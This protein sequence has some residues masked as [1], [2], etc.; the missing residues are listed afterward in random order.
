MIQDYQ[1]VPNK[2]SEQTKNVISVL[3]S[4][5]PNVISPFQILE[6]FTGDNVEIF[7][8]IKDKENFLNLLI[9]QGV[10][11]VL[12][13]AVAIFEVVEIDFPHTLKLA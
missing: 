12:N 11:V 1:I 3:Y 5:F 7:N 10:K 6:K 2:E 8:E 13:W 4:C 9:V